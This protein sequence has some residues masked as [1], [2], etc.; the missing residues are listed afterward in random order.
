MNN[1]ILQHL[2]WALLISSAGPLFA[3]EAPSNAAAEAFFEKRIRPLLARHC[4]ECHA[5]DDVE[6]G[7]R[8]DSLAGMLAGGE[9]GPAIIA[10]KPKESLLVRAVNHGE[11]LQMPPKKKLA[12]AA[13][14]DLATW[15]Q[16]GAKWPNAKPV[17]S[18]QPSNRIKAEFTDE[19]KTFWAFQTPVKPPLPNVRDSDRI[20]TPVDHFILAR[21]E[22]AGLKPAPPADP[23]TLI[24][25]ATFDLIGLPPTPDEIEAFEEESSRN[26][27][28]AF[29]NLIDRLL[30]S[31]HYGERWG[32]RWLDVARY[33][34]SNG[35]D[36]N[37]A[38]ANAFRYRDY[39]VD[40][41]NK[42][43][44]YD[45]F[46]LE[47][48][49][50]DL[51]DEDDPVSSAERITATGFLALGAKMLAE[52]D[53]TKMQMDIIDEQVDTMGRAF[54]ALTLGCARCH[55]HKFDPFSIA[56]YYSLAGIFKSTKT[57]ENFKVVAVWHER[58]VGDPTV[59]AQRDAIQQAADEAQARIDELVANA[60][61]KILHAARTIAGDHFREATEQVRLLKHAD[62]LLAGGKPPVA[63]DSQTIVREAETCE[64][65][66]V[67]RLTDGY[68][69]GIGVIAGPSGKNTAEFDIQVK[70]SGWYFLLSRYA[71]AESRPTNI[72]VNGAAVI[73]GGVGKVTGSWYPDTQ[74]WFVEGVVRLDAGKVVFGLE[75]RA[76]IPHIDKFVFLPVPKS[77]A[78]R[79]KPPTGDASAQQKM[80]LSEPFVGQWSDY[81]RKSEN[82]P[83]SPLT[84]WHAVLQ[85]KP[86]TE[87][88]P[89]A[90]RDVL[91]ELGLSA[92]PSADEA[93]NAV[94]NALGR[95]EKQWLQLRQNDPSAKMLE[96][97]G[98][99]ALKELLYADN[100]P[101]RL[102]DTVESLYPEA[103]REELEQQRKARAE[104]QEQVPTLPVVMAVSD[105]KAENLKI[106]IRGSHFTLGREVPR[107]F[108][109]ILAP[110][111]TPL[112]SN[113]SG[114]LQLARWMTS[115]DHPL[116][117]RV[118]VNR[119]W[120]GH[121]GA[122]LVRSPDNFGQLGERPTHPQLLDW[123]ARRFVESGWSIKTMHRAIM[124]SSTYRMSSRWNRRA[125][126]LDPE[127]RLWWRAN[128]RRLEAEA[129]RD[130]I[131]AVSGLFDRRAGG[132]LLGV[133]NRKYVTSTA[134]VSPDVYNTNRRSIYLPV[135]RSAIYEVLQA[136]D[137]P[138][139]TVSNSRRQSSTVAPQALFM[140]NSKIVSDA[141][142]SMANSLLRDS[143][144]GDTERVRRIYQLAF[145]RHPKDEEVKSA[146]SH[147]ARY[148]TALQLQEAD[149]T[150]RRSKAWASLCRAVIAASEFIF[151]E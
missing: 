58:T 50:G 12:A 106:H 49:A 13:I 1:S 5:G 142:R 100:G 87:I 150:A 101:L 145:G 149:A 77:L 32:R 57:M 91:L 15:I 48:L 70:K 112:P 124:L 116:T 6:S 4:F 109:V 90:A 24:R 16:Q 53:P 105:A 88:K 34:D 9:R 62:S 44:P 138:D 144:H 126:Q 31:P 59:L 29:R 71:A 2:V 3:E 96:A 86:L 14:A 85:G 28:S 42:D 134:N 135:V 45:R 60:N 61:R 39:V 63:R 36:E 27:H 99:Q 56:D 123:L 82:D 108:P 54:M 69:K 7:L 47:Q 114:R 68:G 23:R 25:R 75:R 143:D 132:S 136:F 22:A 151:I 137:F 55:D 51:L 139:P 115:A 17:T 148:E 92:T 66:N 26:P 130:S 89:G 33:G 111:R 19:Q 38:Y 110:N 78:T 128:R 141:A 30:A 84:A 18:P 146:L 81:L 127:N 37:L 103:T 147:I 72:L 113:A 74:K 67:S 102:P 122:A 117:A 43:K 79:K 119:I 8:L 129:I 118:M 133:E 11:Q 40:A 95:A 20:A 97:P 121:F 104:V 35:L 93:T 76:P 120:Q 131:L 21:L 64:R 46:V 10:G 41:F 125:D 94:A 140:M 107:Q 73:S 52:D 80:T 65:G 83:N 98:L